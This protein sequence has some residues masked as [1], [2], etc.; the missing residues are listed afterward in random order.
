MAFPQRWPSGKPMTYFEWKRASEA[1]L[2]APSRY[3]RPGNAMGPQPKPA[4]LQNSTWATSPKARP[5][6]LDPTAKPWSRVPASTSEP[7]DAPRIA[8]SSFPK[9]PSD[10]KADDPLQSSSNPT[11]VIE[12][13]K[14]CTDDILTDF[15]H[16]Y[17]LLSR[18]DT[19]LIHLRS[20][21]LAQALCQSINVTE[22]RLPNQTT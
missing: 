11:S 16:P 3:S 9:P 2:I 21:F 15:S 14:H 1:G 19:S 4:P 13:F 8:S 5:S 20:E 22:Q 12:A 10:K 18:S 17:S 6:T 7:V